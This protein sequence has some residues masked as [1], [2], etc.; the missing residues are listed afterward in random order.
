MINLASPSTALA[1]GGTS[2]QP[3]VTVTGVLWAVPVTPGRIQPSDSAL[4]NQ[5]PGLSQRGPH[6]ALSTQR[7]TV[8]PGPGPGGCQA[9]SEAQSDPNPHSALRFSAALA[10]TVSAGPP[11]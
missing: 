11:R 9:H 2:G 7:G 5:R 3:S 10:I 4:S 8:T 6:S 1:G